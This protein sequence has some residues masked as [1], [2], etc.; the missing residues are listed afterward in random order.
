MVS[1]KPIAD[2][3][4]GSAVQRVQVQIGGSTITLDRSATS[5][6]F[7]GVPGTEYTAEVWA[8]NGADALYPGQIPWN[9]SSS[10]AVTA[11]G[12][13]AAT[14]VTATIVDN[15][16]SVRVDRS[17]FGANGASGVT[18]SV[19]RYGA[20]ASVPGC[21]QASGT[22]VVSPGVVIP[23]AGGDVGSRFVYVV[24]ADNGWGC[25]SAQ[26]G[27]VRVLIPPAPPTVT[28]THQQPVDGRY[29]V[30][31]DTATPST[32]PNTAESEYTVQVSGGG[33][34]S[35]GSPLSGSGP[36]TFTS[37]ITSDGTT[38][39]SEAAAPTTSV[40]PVNANATVVSCV[41]GSP[42]SAVFES[43]GSV[44]WEFQYS[45]RSSLAGIPGFWS[46]W[47]DDPTVP[48]LGALADAQEVVV[49][50]IGNGGDF[51]NGI[52]QNE[53]RQRGSGKSCG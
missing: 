50:T 16:G 48:P 53:L 35:A 46:A 30:A 32:L 33:A 9:R 42:V 38:R 10:G 24:Y 51:T 52:D 6:R 4:P 3:T 12:R 2:P 5:L 1:W 14:A 26:T 23:S 21:S 44:S 28:L 13:P 34:V 45:F 47:S 19:V 39:C 8:E 7:K 29:G 11:A 36:W 27:S 40:S 17:P 31:V 20:T 15:A 18:Y 43:P 37:C 25:A 22:P 49:R 41:A